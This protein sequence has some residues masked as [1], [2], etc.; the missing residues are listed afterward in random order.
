MTLEELVNAV[1]E[2]VQERGG[3]EVYVDCCFCDDQKHRLGINVET[4]VMHCFNCEEKSGDRESVIRS[5]RK[6]YEKIAEAT[7]ITEPFTVDDDEDVEVSVKEKTLKKDKP[8]VTLELPKAYEPLWKEINDRDGRKAL[9]YAL[10]RGVTKE[11]IKHH[12]IGFACAGRYAFRIIFPVYYRQSLH[13]FVC[14]D[15]TGDAE[16]KYLNSYGD[17][18]L[19]NLPSKKIR[20]TKAILVE[21]V[22]DVLAVERANIKGYDVIGCLGSKL[23]TSQY[24]R[25]STYNKVVIWAEPDHA[26][27]DGTIKRA[28]ALQKLGVK[29]KVVVPDEDVETDTDPG[30]MDAN[31]IK[32][33][34][35][36]SV[37]FTPGIANLMRTRIAFS[38]KRFVKRRH[39]AE[40]A[41]K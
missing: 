28:K 26:G 19:Y 21:G 29:V 11:Q 18:G 16:L 38:S 4:G 2:D 24:R 27:V 36:E 22:F 39:N 14:R 6:T 37:V 15:F 25:L 13:G 23:K 33:R 3:G 10:D 5:K 32:R 8:K 30:A 40:N 17:K 34:I 41:K 1:F 9:R 31:E 20:N 35:R 7:S 12:R